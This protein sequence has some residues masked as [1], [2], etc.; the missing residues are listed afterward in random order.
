MRRKTQESR[1]K[2]QDARRKNQDT[3]IKTQESRHKTQD[4]RIKTFLWFGMPFIEFAQF[5]ALKGRQYGSQG[6]RPWK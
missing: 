1:H 2:I 3:R 6:Q 4:A 5:K